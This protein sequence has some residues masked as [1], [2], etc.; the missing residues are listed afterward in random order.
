[1]QL[2]GFP[3]ANDPCYG[4][5]L[6]FGEDK[7]LVPPHEAKG[8]T[9]PEANVAF[10][11]AMRNDETEQEFMKRTCRR[12]AYGDENGKKK[13]KLHCAKIWLH[14]L[15]YEVGEHSLDADLWVLTSDRLMVEGSKSQSPRGVCTKIRNVHIFCM[16]D[17]R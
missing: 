6:N 17:Q 5:E 7:P 16:I 8:D 1:M 3:I 9:P 2:L 13:A 12:C 10:S 15:R 4:G 14:S 11:E